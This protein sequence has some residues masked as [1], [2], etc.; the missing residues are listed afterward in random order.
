MEKVLLVI[1]L[2]KEFYKDGKEKHLLEYIK[3]NRHKYSKIIATLFINDVNSNKNFIECL[4]WNGCTDVNEGSLEFEYDEVIKKNSYGICFK[5]LERFIDCE[6]D[7]IGCDTDACVLANCYLL[8]D[9]NFKFNILREYVYSSSSD[10]SINTYALKIMARN[11]G[12][13]LK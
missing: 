10:V 8:F 5:D 13:S 7:V 3:Q 4:D 6:V 1:D 12:K 11:F 2:Q 9:N